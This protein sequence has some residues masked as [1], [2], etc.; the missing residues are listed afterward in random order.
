MLCATCQVRRL[1]EA[2]PGISWNDDMRAVCG[3]PGSFHSYFVLV[4]LHCYFVLLCLS[5][6]NDD[7]CAMC[8]EACSLLRPLLRML[9]TL[10]RGNSLP[11][12]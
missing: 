11:S 6:P 10:N 4:S 5:V 9:W 2:V 8:C 3:T 7:Q 1:T 12:P